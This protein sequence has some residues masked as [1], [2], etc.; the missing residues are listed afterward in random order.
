MPRFTCRI[1][2]TNDVIQPADIVN[3]DFGFLTQVFAQ[4]TSSNIQFDI[5]STPLQAPFPILRPGSVGAFDLHTMLRVLT[6]NRLDARPVN[7][8]A[9]ILARRYKGNEGAFGMMFDEGYVFPGDPADDV[10]EASV[11]GPPREGCAIFLDA[12]QSSRGPRGSAG[13]DDEVRFSALHEIGHVFN[14][15]HD[16][17]SNNIMKQSAALGAVKRDFWFLTSDDRRRLSEDPLPFD[18]HPGGSE[19]ARGASANA[20]IA[21]RY[22]ERDAALA[23]HMSASLSQSAAHRFEPIELDLVISLAPDVRRGARIPDQIDPGYDAFRVWIEEPSGA[24]RML[25]SPRRYCGAP[26]SI[27]ITRVR[28]FRRDVSIGREAGGPVFRQEGLHHVWC[29]MSLGR[30]GMLRSNRVPLRIKSLS[31][32]TAADLE[33]RQVFTSTPG[34]VLGYSRLWRGSRAFQEQALALAN[35]FPN[36]SWSPMLRYAIVRASAEETGSG[37]RIAPALSDDVVRGLADA[38]MSDRV[39]GEHRTRKVEKMVSTISSA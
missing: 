9:L 38:V 6:K 4:E 23:L 5:D 21:W 37:S 15:Q 12:I 35:A 30:R 17:R 13:F 29:E 26:R 33:A 36:E 20:P 2:C 8:I 1:G 14:L 34:V 39:L 25:R 31:E 10:T 7:T 3:G 32:M 16:N 24:R 22:D 27:T 28:P 19:F 18:C 11:L